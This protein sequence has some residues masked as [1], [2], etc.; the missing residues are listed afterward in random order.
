MITV[1]PGIYFCRF[2]IEPYLKE[3]KHKQFIDEEVLQRYWDVGGVRIE[4]DVLI[5]ADGY[6]NLTTAPKGINKMMQVMYEDYDE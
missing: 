4:D 1:E 2:I 3:E 5:T 6:E